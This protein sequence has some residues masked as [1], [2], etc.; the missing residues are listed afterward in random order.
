MRKVAATVLLGAW[1][2]LAGITS[3]T[4]DP[5]IGPKPNCVYRHQNEGINNG[6]LIRSSGGFRAYLDHRLQTATAA[7]VCDP[8]RWIR[9]VGNIWCERLSQGNWVA[10]HCGSYGRVILRE[11]A[12]GHTHASAKDYSFESTGVDGITTVYGQW[13]R[14]DCDATYHSTV[15]VDRVEIGGAGW[16]NLGSYGTSKPWSC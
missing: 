10:T 16:G 6:F 1:M 12:D 14:V 7:R 15:Q 11:T 9:G 5:G 3:A 4:A 13:S 8:D 2:T